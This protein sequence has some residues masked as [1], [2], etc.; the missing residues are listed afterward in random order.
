MIFG[1]LQKTPAIETQPSFSLK[2]KKIWGNSF[3]ATKTPQG[4]YLQI[5]EPVSLRTPLVLNDTIMMVAGQVNATAFSSSSC[6]FK[7]VYNS[8]PIHVP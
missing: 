4:S 3:R 7:G 5:F 8:R 2:P 1:R 6:F